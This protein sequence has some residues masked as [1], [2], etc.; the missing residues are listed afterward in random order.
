MD[1]ETPSNVRE[2]AIAFESLRGHEETIDGKT[3]YVHDEVRIVEV[4]PIRTTDRS[5]SAPDPRVK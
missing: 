4:S 5:L 2:W 1:A 3:V